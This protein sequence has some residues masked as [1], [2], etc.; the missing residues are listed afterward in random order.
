M[1][2]DDGHYAARWDVDCRT[3]RMRVFRMWSLQ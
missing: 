2:D 3:N 1:S